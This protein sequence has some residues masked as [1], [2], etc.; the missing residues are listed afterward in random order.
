MRRWSKFV[1]SSFRVLAD[2][3]LLLLM[4]A[5]LIVGLVELIRFILRVWQ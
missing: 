5:I 4:L 3:H 1:H 2:I